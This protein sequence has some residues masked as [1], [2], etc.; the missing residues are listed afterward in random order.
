MET[1]AKSC[2]SHIFTYLLR[3]FGNTQTNI[4]QNMV[5]SSETRIWTSCRQVYTKFMVS[6]CIQEDKGCFFR[7]GGGKRGFLTTAIS[8]QQFLKNLQTKKKNIRHFLFSKHLLTWKSSP[9]LGITY[10]ELVLIGIIYA[11]QRC[12]TR[13]NLIRITRP[14][15]EQQSISSP[16]R[17]KNPSRGKVGKIRFKLPFLKNVSNQ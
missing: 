9:L 5:A 16:T 2:L 8:K 13:N 15:S 12:P 17:D 10:S 6:K 1:A 7:Q 11:E 3:T 14:Y 4:F